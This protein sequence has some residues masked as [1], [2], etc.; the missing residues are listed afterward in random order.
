MDT[1]CTTVAEIGAQGVRRLQQLPTHLRGYQVSLPRSLMPYAA[2]RQENRQSVSTQQL[3]SLG[4]Y[5]ESATE[6]GQPGTALRPTLCIALTGTVNR[7]SQWTKHCISSNHPDPFSLYG[8]RQSPTP[9]EQSL[10]CNHLM[11]NSFSISEPDSPN[12]LQHVADLGLSAPYPSG[13]NFPTVS[14]IF[15]QESSHLQPVQIAQQLAQPR[16]NLSPTSLL[17]MTMAALTVGTTG[18]RQH[19]YILTPAKPQHQHHSLR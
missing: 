9:P 4:L 7:G 3:Q 6:D 19:K 14:S 11:D 16:G 12:L 13:C 1:P 10:H 2:S 17:C 18:Q 5:T 15:R 8:G